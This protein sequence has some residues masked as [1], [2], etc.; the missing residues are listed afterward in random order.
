MMNWFRWHHGTVNDPKWRVISKKSGVPIPVVLSV[1]AYF[2]ER[3]SSN[4]TPR[5]ANETSMKR[6]SVSGWC[7]DDIAAC[8]DIDPDQVSAVYEAMQGRVLDGDWL[9][10]WEHRQPKREREHDVSTDRVKAFR[11]RK[12]LETPC[13]AKERQETPRLD[14][15]RE[16]KTTPHTPP[17]DGI[18]TIRKAVWRLSGLSE[19]Q[20]AT[21]LV[22]L[23]AE[24]L[25]QSRTWLE[26]YPLQAIVDAIADAYDGADLRK[27]PIRNPWKYLDQVVTGINDKKA[28]EPTSYRPAQEEPW[29]QRMKMVKQ[30][31]WYGDIW[32]PEPDFGGC[33]APQDIKDA[34]FAAKAE[35]DAARCGSRSNGP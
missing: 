10:G 20:I 11:E 12:R 23:S 15:I 9:T 18:D 30:G 4:E 7:K 2:L 16:D 21:K 29:P 3:A 27:E 31:I 8:F 13:N 22:S 33:R 26:S 35:K 6:G 34:Y 28:T 32:G 19:D 14:K 1:F 17:L 25:R 5:N 24:G